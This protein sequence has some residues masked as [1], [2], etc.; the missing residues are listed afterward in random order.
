[1]STSHSLLLSL[2]YGSLLW[3]YYIAIYTGHILLSQ[4]FFIGA[5]VS[6]SAASISNERV[7]LLLAGVMIAMSF[8]SSCISE[9]PYLFL[10][11]LVGFFSKTGVSFD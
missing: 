5:L 11:L 1:M 8:F 2:L 9:I 4:A 3:P 6:A 7:L 10:V